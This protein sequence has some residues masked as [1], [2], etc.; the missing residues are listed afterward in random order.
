MQNLRISRKQGISAL[1]A[2]LIGLTVK[3]A[4]PYIQDLTDSIDYG[5]PL[6]PA[7]GQQFGATDFPD[8]IETPDFALY[9][10]VPIN[11]RGF[12][13]DKTVAERICFYADP[14]Q[15]KEGV[16]IQDNNFDRKVDVI[17]RYEFISEG[18]KM[19][20]RLKMHLEIP[21][22]KEQTPYERRQFQTA[23]IKFSQ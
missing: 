6:K 22:I 5:H 7:V 23:D 12:F 15:W 21:F 4:H 10:V 20:P 8:R 9:S 3:V 1:V 2:A 18:E 13:V 11:P 16:C 17:D 19:M 14:G